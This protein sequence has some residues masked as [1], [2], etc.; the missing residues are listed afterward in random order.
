MTLTTINGGFQFAF[1]A[2]F[3]RSHAFF[4]FASSFSSSSFETVNICGL[5]RP[6][7]RLLC[8]RVR[9]ELGMV[10]CLPHSNPVVS[11]LLGA[12]RN[13]GTKKQVDFRGA[14]R[15]GIPALAGVDSVPG[16]FVF[17]W[18]SGRAQLKAPIISAYPR[19]TF[20][21]ISELSFPPTQLAHQS[22]K[23]AQFLNYHPC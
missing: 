6:C 11:T 9:R 10:C 7:V 14:F 16:H 21:R 17:P 12:S 22:P 18:L 5:R 19:R 23:P 15:H 2:S 8:C 13:S 20:P 1:F 3:L 4:C